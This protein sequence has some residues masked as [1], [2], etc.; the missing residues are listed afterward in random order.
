MAKADLFIDEFVDEDKLEE[1][2]MGKA[3]AL[4]VL[5]E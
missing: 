1:R 3:K 5:I 2:R 4:I